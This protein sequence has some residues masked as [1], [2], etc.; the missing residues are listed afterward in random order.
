MEPAGQGAQQQT[1]YNRCSHWLLLAA[2]V[3]GDFEFRVLI[4][5]VIAAMLARVNQSA[6]VLRI[7]ALLGRVQQLWRFARPGSGFDRR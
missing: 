1:R 7:E 6:L 2:F 3:A 5:V 4:A